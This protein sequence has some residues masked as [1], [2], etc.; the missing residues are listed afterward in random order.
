MSGL[1]STRTL[2]WPALQYRLLRTLFPVPLYPLTLA[3]NTPDAPAVVPPDPWPGNPARGK[4][5]RDGRYAFE[6]HTLTNVRDPWIAASNERHPLRWQRVLHEFVW[7]RDLRALGGDDARQTARKLTKA[8]IDHHGKWSAIAWR[9]DISAMRIMAWLTHYDVF[10]ASANDAFRHEM[11]A[12]I[13]RQV[14]HLARILPAEVDGAERLTALKGLVCGAIAL[15]CPNA[16]EENALALLGQ[17]LARQVL[18]DGGHIERN[19]TLQLRVLCDLIDVR[20][21]LN[22]GCRELP[23]FLQH[24]IDRLAPMLR[25]FRH[26]D[27]SLAHFNGSN[28]GDGELI[29]L[30]LSKAD[31]RGRAPRSAPHSGFERLS[32]GRMLVL[33]DAGQPMQ[34]FDR[35]ACA[36]TL[37]FEASIGRDRLIVNCGAATGENQQWRWACR[38]TAAH[39][40]AQVDDRNSSEIRDNG[41]FGRKPSVILCER[42]DKDGNSLLTM[43]HDGYLKSLSI[44][45]KRRLYL[46]ADGENLRGEDILSGPADHPFT[47]RFHL[48]PRVQASL[49][50]D[51]H[52]ALI[53]L[54]GGAGWRLRADVGLMRIEDS[55]Y[56]DDPYVPR[57]SQQIVI[58]GR[59]GGYG[60]AVNWELK[61]HDQ[62]STRDWT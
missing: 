60:I 30:A 37:S 1:R 51:N 28:A 14:R 23:E 49:A 62:K 53:R 16:V 26:G 5:I 21:T 35:A 58:E 15:P 2:A 9:A 61:R 44:L 4:E 56:L 42:E 19:P 39:S 43:S 32:A 55:I 11:M 47:I 54:S 34:G 8:W 33:V 46:T 24:A 18:P 27:H 3:G 22:A 57:R 7:L 25:F 20:A 59:T 52:Q 17:E 12:C 29:D 10:F 31:A 6:G 40:T 45:H 36:G 38:T 48:H 41:A 50:K 13:G